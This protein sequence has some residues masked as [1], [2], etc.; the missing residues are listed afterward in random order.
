LIAPGLVALSLACSGR[1]EAPTTSTNASA[2]AGNGSSDSCGSLPA[3]TTQNA[4]AKLII[5]HNATD[6]DTG[7]HGAFDDHGWSVL[8][9]FDPAGRQV[10]LVEPQSALNRLTMSYI[11]F[12]SREPPND[13]F[14]IADLK[15]AFPEGKYEVRGASLDG[16][17]LVGHATFSHDIPAAAVVTSPSHVQDEEDAGKA[18]VSR[19]GLVIRWEPVTKTVDGAAVDIT[20]YEIIVAPVVTDDPN[21]FSRPGFDAHVPP[22]VRSLTIPPEVLIPDTVHEFEILAIERSGNQTITAG[23]FKTD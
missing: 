1:T 15:A 18:V 19:A 4:T 17:T 12:E 23:F 2:A 10:L 13:E 3:K 14:S 11:F 16:T 5:E 6:G 21:G 7:V 22:S 20:G 9:V 8:C